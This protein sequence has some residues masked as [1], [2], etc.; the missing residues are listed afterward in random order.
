MSIW[1]KVLLGL[2][3]VASIAFFILSARALQTHKYWREQALKREAELAEALKNHAELKDEVRQLAVDL[4]EQLIDRGRVWYG[5]RP[6]QVSAATGEVS[7]MTDFPDPHGIE[8]QT[9]LWVFDERDLQNGGSYLGQFAVA[10]VGGQGN[11]RLLQLQPCIRMSQDQLQRLQQSQATNGVTWA[12]YET[13]PAD[14][15]QSLAGLDAEQLK[16]LLPESTVEEYTMDGQLATLEAVKQRGLQ[17]KVFKVDETGEMVKRT[18]PEEIQKRGLEVEV[19]AENEQGRY[20][21]QL[22]DYEE[23]FRQYD[24]RRTTLADQRDATTRENNYITNVHDDAKLQLQHRQNEKDR[25][26]DERTKYFQER[27][28]AMDHLEAVTGK[29]A[30]I[31][32]AIEEA[33][34]T[35]Q[36]MAGEIARIQREASRLIDEETRKMARA[37]AG[38]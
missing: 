38:P 20:V 31:R 16:A 17:G 26:K 35:N 22:R 8:T 2:I 34:K 29:L 14:N 6:Q 10:A 37:D 30:A 5:C 18:D 23:L 12:L 25:L 33:I 1:N 19:E 15:H 27:N 11:N 7:V 3:F 36:A 32:A 4:Y 21:R 9:V 24:L 28:V 13:M